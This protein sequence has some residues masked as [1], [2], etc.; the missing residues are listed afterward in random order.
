MG[1]V[2]DRVEVDTRYGGGSRATVAKLRVTIRISSA[3]LGWQGG[4]YTHVIASAI[5]ACQAL[6]PHSDCRRVR[7]KRESKEGRRGV[8][9]GRYRRTLGSEVSKCSFFIS[10]WSLLHHN[11]VSFDTD[12]YTPGLSENPVIWQ[13]QEIK[14]AIDDQLWANRSSEMY[15]P[16][17]SQ[18]DPPTRTCV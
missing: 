12:A 4:E 14:K 10:L 7:G 15:P 8:G 11:L 9:M 2:K 6:S 3:I 1:R 13:S 16:T 18:T 5:L 17:H